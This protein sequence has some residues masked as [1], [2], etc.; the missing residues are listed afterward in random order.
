MPTPKQPAWKSAKSCWM[1]ESTQ[2]GITF[3][4]REQ[5]APVVH[6]ALVDTVNVVVVVDAG[7]VIELGD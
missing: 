7:N 2:D 4:Y 5:G 6:V 3:S 1:W